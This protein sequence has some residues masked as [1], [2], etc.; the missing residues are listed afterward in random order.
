MSNTTPTRSPPDTDGASRA[1]GTA[2]T[3]TKVA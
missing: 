1:D 2:G 3:E